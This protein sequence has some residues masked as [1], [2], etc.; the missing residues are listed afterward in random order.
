MS[1][2]AFVTGGLV[3]LFGIWLF[4]AIFSGS[5]QLWWFYIYPVVIVCIGISLVL[6]WKSEDKIE[7]RKD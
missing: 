3:V 4:F 2:S 7:E 5:E 6:F 1:K